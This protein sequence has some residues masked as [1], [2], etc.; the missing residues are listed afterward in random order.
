MSQISLFSITYWI[1]CIYCYVWIVRVVY[2]IIRCLFGT[3][4]TIRRY[5]Q[6]S[7]AVVA[8]ITDEFGSEMVKQL[9]GRGFNIIIIDNNSMRAME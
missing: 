5:G 1:G 4:C 9:A 2:A 6:N 8:G 3:K 7:W